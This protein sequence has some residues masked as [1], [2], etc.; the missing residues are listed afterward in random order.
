MFEM[1]K[2]PPW[3]IYKFVDEDQKP[4]QLMSLTR[5]RTLNN[6]D[7]IVVAEPASLDHCSMSDSRIRIPVNS[8]RPIPTIFS[9]TLLA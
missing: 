7:Q 4:K 9:A 5:L 2:V 3:Q 1:D 6:M 8:V